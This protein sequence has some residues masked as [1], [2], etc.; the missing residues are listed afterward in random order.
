MVAVY[1]WAYFDNEAFVQGFT[2][3]ILSWIFPLVAI[4]VLALSPGDTG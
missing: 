3:L 4:I 1:G 2:D